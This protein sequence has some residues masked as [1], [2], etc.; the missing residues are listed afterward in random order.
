MNLEERKSSMHVL[1]VDD[2][3]VT[4]DMVRS[5]LKGIGFHK[6]SLAE[7]G[8]AAL[9]KL[10]HEDS[11]FDLIVCDWNMPHV[12]GLQVLEAIRSDDRLRRIPFL[13]LTAEAYRENVTAALKAGVS[14]Y[15]V[16]PFTA[17][18][19]DQKIEEILMKQP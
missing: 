2:H 16:K 10:Q 3:I 7:D 8:V 19:L 5:I 15:V 17:E 11:D 18:T 13:M 12:S 4:R 1:V 9:S 14:N 6:I